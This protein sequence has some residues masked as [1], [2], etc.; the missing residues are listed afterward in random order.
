ML[1]LELLT[2]CLFGRTP[3]Q[4]IES[5]GESNECKQLVIVGFQMRRLLSDEP[6]TTL[7]S[8]N[9]ATQVIKERVQKIKV[10]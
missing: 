6:L 9:T 10:I 8:L 2:M 1:S 4:L 7:P 5:V 3:K